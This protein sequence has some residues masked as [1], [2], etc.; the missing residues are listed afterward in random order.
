MCM[1][2]LGSMAGSQSPGR[3]LKDFGMN[4]SE[5]SAN[6]FNLINSDSVMGVELLLNYVTAHFH[7]FSKFVLCLWLLIIP[8]IPVCR[9]P[10]CILSLHISFDVSN[11]PRKEFYFMGSLLLGFCHDCLSGFQIVKVFEH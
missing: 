9:K 1:T 11:F 2:V 10:N 8:L 4:T 7:R 6:A 5:H 3:W